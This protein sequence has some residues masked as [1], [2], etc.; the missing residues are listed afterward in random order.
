MNIAGVLEISLFPEFLK[1]LRVI[2]RERC[3]VDL[4]DIV[5][6]RLKGVVGHVCRTSP[7]GLSIAH[8]V[9]AVH[10]FHTRDAAPGITQRLNKCTCARRSRILTGSK[11]RLRRFVGVIAKANFHAALCFFAQCRRQVRAQRIA[12]AHVVNCKI[13]SLFRAS[14]E[15]RQPGHHVVSGLFAF[16]EEKHRK[17]V[18]Y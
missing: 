10:Q 13:E 6:L 11:I 8:D 12:E 14:D 15:H 7:D 18:H 16:S 4:D 9:F 17:I 3:R 1:I 5:F 2:A